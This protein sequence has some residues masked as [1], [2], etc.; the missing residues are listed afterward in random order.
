MNYPIEL[1]HVEYRYPRAKTNVFNDLSLRFEASKL[2]GVVG[3]SGVG[4]T[5]LLSLLSGLTVPN[6]GEVL[7]LGED[8]EKKDRY[9]YRAKQIGVIF[10]SYNLLPHLTAI[11]NV[12]LGI[13]V[14]GIKVKDKKGKALALLHQVGLDEVTAHRKILKCSGGEQQRIA[15]ARTLAYEPS[16][17]L[18]DEPTGNLDPETANS[19]MDL[20]KKLAYEKNK[21]VI[22]VTHSLDV[23]KQCDEIITLKKVL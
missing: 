9:T 11:E 16:V 5:T 20:F 6:S 17:I 3:K 23:A 13:D 8:I 14:S 15:I 22:I 2:I 12:I 21:C 19:I 18:A 4:K 10:Q 7:F 1:N